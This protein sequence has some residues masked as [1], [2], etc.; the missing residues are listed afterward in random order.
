MLERLREDDVELLRIKRNSPE[1]N[2]YMLFRE[3]ITPEQQ[4]LWFTQIDNENNN[5]FII[6]DGDRK[7]GLISGTEID[8]DN[9][10]TGNGGLFFWD[11]TYWGTNFPLCAALLLTDLSF[12]LQ[13][14]KTC[15][16][17][18]RDNVRAINFNKAL[19]YEL[20][21]DQGSSTLVNY[22]LTEHSY[23]RA[24]AKVKSI[25]LG[26]VDQHISCFVDDPL[27]ASTRKFLS[28]YNNLPEENKAKI[29]FVENQ[30]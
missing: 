23:V 4:R 29:T 5:Y 11:T 2:T 22:E 28:V 26:K 18:L 24:T 7:V 9:M 1:V 12:V 6:R 3:E 16:R 21:P 30:I 14:K 10:I 20:M 17:V 8:W 13:F 19:G 25:L 27:H 15:V